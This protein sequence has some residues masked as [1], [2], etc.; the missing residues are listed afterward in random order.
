M[1]LLFGFKPLVFRRDFTFYVGIQ[2]LIWIKVLLAFYFIGKGITYSGLPLVVQLPF[3]GVPAFQFVYQIPEYVF[4]QVMHLCILLW[5]FLLAKHVQKINMHEI[6]V[7]FFIATVLHNVGYWLTKAH[8]SLLFSV[9]DFITDYLALWV[10]LAGFLLLLRI[11]P[12]LKKI[13]IPLVE[14]E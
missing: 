5:V 14:K 11:F 1:P 7:L 8:P 3:V 4:H 2:V 10:F 13:I 6:A 9:K 12:R